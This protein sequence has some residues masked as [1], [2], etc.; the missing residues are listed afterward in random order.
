MCTCEDEHAGMHE[1]TPRPVQRMTCG[2]NQPGGLSSAACTTPR[3]RPMPMLW[4]AGQGRAGQGRKVSV[5]V[6][7]RRPVETSLCRNW[8]VTASMEVDRGAE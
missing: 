7:A 6:F 2:R 8:E 4:Q 1:H 5:W 3:L